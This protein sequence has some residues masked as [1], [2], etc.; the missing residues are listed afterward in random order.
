M[1]ESDCTEPRTC[2]FYAHQHCAGCN[3]IL[4]AVGGGGDDGSQVA[5]YDDEHG[6][7]ARKCDDCSDSLL[8]LACY[9][10]SPKCG[11]CIE[12]EA[13]PC[14]VCEHPIGPDFVDLNA[15]SV[16]GK[17]Y[18]TSDQYLVCRTCAVLRVV[19]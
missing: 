5:G 14:R 4:N 1:Y 12:F 16:N 6:N 15:T 7:G 3:S 8:C 9:K 2:T 17:L 10:T 19:A 18:S 11:F 13:K